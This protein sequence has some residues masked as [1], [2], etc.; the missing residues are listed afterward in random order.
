MPK[1]I[2]FNAEDRFNF[3]LALIGYLGRR[4]VVTIAEAATHF[5]VEPDYLRKAVMS[6]NDAGLLQ[7]DYAHYHFLID[8][9]LAE[10]SAP[11]RDQTGD[12]LPEV[13]RAIEVHG[14]RV[15]REVRIAP[16]HHFEIGDLRIARQKNILFSL[17]HKL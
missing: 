4:G 5:E 8:V 7:N 2:G 9:D 14:L 11:S 16:V 6:V 10:Q 17:R 1:I 12:A 3:L 15:H 13:R